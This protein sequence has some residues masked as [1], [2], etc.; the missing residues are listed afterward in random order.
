M[1]KARRVRLNMTPA[2][3][4][5]ISEIVP[6]DTVTVVG[7]CLEK[8]DPLESPE[9]DDTPDAIE[10]YNSNSSLYIA[11]GHQVA[12]LNDPPSFNRGFKLSAV[13]P[14]SMGGSWAE[15][16]MV[17]PEAMRKTDR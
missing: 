17:A 5:A 16:L 7:N 9:T 15:V 1:I 14:D 4:D 13:V 8:A 2:T 11:G 3:D 10:Y 12:N 6:D